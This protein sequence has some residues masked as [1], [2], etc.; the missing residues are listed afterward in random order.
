M[1]G[2][3][4]LDA[5]DDALVAAPYFTAIVPHDQRSEDRINGPDVD[6]GAVEYFAIEVTNTNDSGAGSLRDAVTQANGAGGGTISFQQATFGTTQQTITLTSGEI[7]LTQ[8]MSITGPSPGVIISGGNS[9][10]ILKVTAGVVTLDHLRL[11]NGNSNF[12]GGA[13][14]ISGVGTVVTMTDVAVSNSDAAGVGGGIEVRDSAVL[15]MRDCTLSGNAAT[16]NGGAIA[17][18]SSATLTLLNSTISDNT[19]GEQGGGITTSNSTTTILNCTIAEN[20]ADFGNVAPV[21]DGGGIRRNSGTVSV[22]NSIIANNTDASSGTVHPDVSGQFVSLGHN[23][24]GKSDGLGAGGTPF[25]NGVNGDIVGTI[26]SPGAPAAFRA[27]A[28]PIDRADTRAS[29]PGRQSGDRCGRRR[30]PRSRS[31]GHRAGSRSARTIPHRR[32]GGGH[33]RGRIS[34]WRHREAR[35]RRCAMQRAGSRCRQI[36]HPPQLHDRRADCAS[37]HLMPLPPLR[38]RTT[39]SP[40]RP[41]R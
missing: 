15:T 31:V 38:R 35:H 27:P 13:L 14:N 25:Q 34:E 36:P 2:S 33:G 39:P 26:A 40:A 12:D 18:N 10:R 24:I 7:E 9:S 8:T 3:P 21:G 11:D 20:T 28:Q 16:T 1:P 41:T 30:A 32:P 17:A 4:V 19:A 23:L 6:I 37:A 29:A 5:G 22:G